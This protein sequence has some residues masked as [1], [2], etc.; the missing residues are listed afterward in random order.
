MFTFLAMETGWTFDYMRR[1]HFDEFLMAYE[2]AIQIKTGAKF[3]PYRSMDDKEKI[4]QEVAEIHA[5]VGK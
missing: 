2:Y 4:R 3:K 5:R 1:M